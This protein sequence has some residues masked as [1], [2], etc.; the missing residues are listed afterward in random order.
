MST[1][2]DK[3]DRELAEKLFGRVV[4]WNKRPPNETPTVSHE[5]PKTSPE[6]QNP[7]REPPQ[8]QSDQYQERLSPERL[9]ELAQKVVDVV[10]AQRERVKYEKAGKKLN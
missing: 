9:E 8:T 5:P 7:G 4:D 6:G 3:K 2:G 10:R 1:D